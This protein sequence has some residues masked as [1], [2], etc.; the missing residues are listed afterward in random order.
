MD[1]STT[2]AWI[3]QILARLAVRSCA[4]VASVG[5]YLRSRER[6]VTVAMGLGVAMMAVAYNESSST[7]SIDLELRVVER[8]QLF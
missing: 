4:I 8:G 6:A 7:S 5:M 3:L 2:Q 1:G